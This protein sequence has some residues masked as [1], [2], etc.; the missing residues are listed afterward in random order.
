[1]IENHAKKRRGKLV[2]LD[3][4]SLFVFGGPRNVEEMSLPSR[5]RNTPRERAT[6]SKSARSRA[7]I[8]S[9]RDASDFT[10][11]FVSPNSVVHSNT[12]AQVLDLSKGRKRGL[13]A[14]LEF[15]SRARAN[16]HDANDKNKFSF[17]YLLA[18]ID[19]RV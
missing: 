11:E 13:K 8:L 14:G 12:N 6:R 1:M 18:S 15:Q 17:T 5:R 4:F 7:E 16:T 3:P 2:S 19:V 10:R 9:E